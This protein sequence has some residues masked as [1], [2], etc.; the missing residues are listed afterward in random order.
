MIRRSTVYILNVGDWFLDGSEKN[1]A[2]PSQ[3]MSVTLAPPD[4]YAVSFFR[5]GRAPR[6]EG[7]E[8]VYCENTGLCTGWPGRHEDAVRISVAGDCCKRRLSG[9]RYLRRPP[10]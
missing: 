3:K 7:D 4:L 2:V 6:I 10:P 9:W 5:I 1:I 8:G